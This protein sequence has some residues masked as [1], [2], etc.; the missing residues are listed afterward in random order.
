MS[1]D[2][3]WLILTPVKG[4]KNN[5]VYFGD[6]SAIEN[7]NGRV[8]L[9]PMIEQLTADYEVSIFDIVFYFISRQVK[10]ENKNKPMVLKTLLN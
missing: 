3:H 4:C 10:K 6:L 5:L 8:P 9:I 7:I 2:G 1:D